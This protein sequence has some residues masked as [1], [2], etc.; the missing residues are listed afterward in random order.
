M[1]KS[2]HHAEGLTRQPAGKVAERAGNTKIG[3]PGLASAV[4]RYEGR[5]LEI[6]V[7]VTACCRVIE[8]HFLQ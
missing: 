6:V 5:R 3:Y 2:L 7:A 4:D 8:Y 1:N